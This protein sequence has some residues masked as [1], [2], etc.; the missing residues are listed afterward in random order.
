MYCCHSWHGI[1]STM[2]TTTTLFN[3]KAKYD[4][5]IEAAEAYAKSLTQLIASATKQLYKFHANPYRVVCEKMREIQHYVAVIYTEFS[6]IKY[7]KRGS[8]CS[9]IG[10]GKVK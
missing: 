1:G 6:W 3:E 8:L 10:T 9:K 5:K 4:H 7:P 2:L